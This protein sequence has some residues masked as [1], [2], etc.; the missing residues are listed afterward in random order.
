VTNL[1]RQGACAER[2]GDDFYYQNILV[3]VSNDASETY[4][5]LLS[6][7]HIRRTW[8]G[9]LATCSPSSFPIDRN[10][11]DIPPQGSGCGRP[12]PPK[13]TRFNVKVHMKSPEYYTIDATPIV[14]PDVAYC[15]AIGFTDGRSL[16][17]LRPEYG[18]FED[19][20]A[21]E[22]WRVGKAKDTGRYGPTWTIEGTGKYCTGVE[23]NCT[24]NPDTQY[25]IFVYRSGKFRAADQNGAY[26]LVDVER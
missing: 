6:S 12:Y 16:C 26:G 25:Q 4:D 24:V 11:A 19:R 17:M 10:S 9:Y 21:C 5:V 7:N 22:N 23:S 15:A 18:P 14:G 1:R 13:V 8:S 2:D 3:K 20:A